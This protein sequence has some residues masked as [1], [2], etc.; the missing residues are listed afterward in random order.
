MFGHVNPVNVFFEIIVLLFAICVHES[1]HAWMANRLGDPDGE[2]AGRVVEPHRPHEPDA[3][4][5][6]GAGQVGRGERP[7]PGSAASTPHAQ[8]VTAT[9]ASH[10]FDR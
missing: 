5:G 3:C 4:R 1:A 8:I 2:D 7:K 10:G 6:R 9:I